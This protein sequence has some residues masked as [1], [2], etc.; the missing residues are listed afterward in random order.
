ML[1]SE[2]KWKVTGPEPGVRDYSQTEPVLDWGAEWGLDIKGHV[3]VWGNGPPQSSSGVPAW[4]VERFQDP[5]LNEADEQELRGLLEH[6][7]RDSV[8]FFEPGADAWIRAL[9]EHYQ[10]FDADA[11]LALDRALSTADRITGREALVL[12]FNDAFYLLGV[13][14][15][16]GLALVA[17]LGAS[18]GDGEK[19]ARDRTRRDPSFNPARRRPSWGSGSAPP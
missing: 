3:L 18:R 13:A 11:T 8:S 9:A 19:R 17:M 15:L 16:V 2:A 14:L 4:V 5:S 12:G 1:E 7:V 6:H 10:R